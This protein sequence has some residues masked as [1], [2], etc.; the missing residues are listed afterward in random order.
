MAVLP[1]FPLGSVLLPS[2]FLP[3]HLFEPRYRQLIRDCMA[4]SQ[5]FGV[6][7]IERGSEVGGGDVR[8]GVGTVARVVQAH[9][10]DD[11][12]WAVAAVGTRRIRVVE[13]L[14][15]A[16]YPRAEVEDW[17]D[18]VDGDAPDDEAVA[19]VVATLRRVLA[20][21]SELGDPAAD[22]TQEISADPSL[23]SFQIAALSPIGPM[24]RQ[25]LLCTAGTN[26]RLERLAD[27]LTD[28]E[29]FLHQRLRLDSSNDLDGPP[30]DE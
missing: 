16:P 2:V 24:D 14:E 20:L 13:W 6:V 21:A 17:D 22:A 11:G 19:P 1:M 5:E 8:A 27:L 10:L 9:E 18:V 30:I 28:E 23:A 26:E 3:L 7:L 25:A 12:R 29:S 4:G 15:D